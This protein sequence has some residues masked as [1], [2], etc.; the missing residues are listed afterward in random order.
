[1]KK[2]IKD[3]LNKIWGFAEGN[4]TIFCQAVWLAIESG[5]IPVTGIALKLV[6]IVMFLITGESARRHYKKGFFSTK[7]I[8]TEKK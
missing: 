7:I 2:K 4:K 1:M 8:K 5:L 6:R 3:I